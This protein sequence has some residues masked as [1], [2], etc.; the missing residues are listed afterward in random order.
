MVLLSGSLVV[1]FASTQHTLHSPVLGTCFVCRL[2]FWRD[3]VLFGTAMSINLLLLLL[4]LLI[5]LFTAIVFSLGGTS[6]DK[7]H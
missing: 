6:A 3:C 2:L 7:T 5:L 1:P 4:L